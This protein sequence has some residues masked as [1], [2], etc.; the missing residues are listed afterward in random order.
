MASARLHC[1][2]RETIGDSHSLTSQQMQDK[3]TSP[4]IDRKQPSSRNGCCP[5]RPIPATFAVVLALLT[6]RNE[7]EHRHAQQCSH[8]GANTNANAKLDQVTHMVSYRGCVTTATVHVP[9]QRY[10]P[11]LWC[12]GRASKTHP[13]PVSRGNQLCVWPFPLLTALTSK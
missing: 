2:W 1:L 7:A 4:L 11:G 10:F 9:C 12:L 5:T 6:R 13:P 3:V 8:T